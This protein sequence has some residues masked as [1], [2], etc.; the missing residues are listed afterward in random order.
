[1][2]TETSIPELAAEVIVDAHALDRHDD[3]SALQAFAWAL[4]SDIDHEQGLR[5]FADVIQGQLT[6]I[7]R[8][9]D[10]KS[11]IDLINAK[12]ELISKYKLQRPQDYTPDDITEMRAE[13]ARLGGLRDRLT[14]KT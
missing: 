12:I 11:I 10:R 2:T 1:M 5:E 8:S 6:V 9:L 3:E 13:I 4:G 14:A 7:A